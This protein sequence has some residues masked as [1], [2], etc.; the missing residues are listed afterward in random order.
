MMI[1]RESDMPRV[2]RRDGLRLLGGLPLLLAGCGDAPRPNAASSTRPYHHTEA[3]FR[4]PPGSPEPGGGFGDW[5]GFFYRRFVGDDRAITL[6][7]DHVLKKAE[8]L[9]GLDRDSETATWLGHACFLLR[10]D[11]RTV[12][13]DPFLTSHAS[14]FPSFGPERLAPPG[15]PPRELPPIDVVLLSHNHYD[16]LD[17]PTLERLP[18]LGEAALVC[19]LRVGD[20]ID[21]GSFG[22]VHELDWGDRVEARGLTITAVPAV[23][24]SKRTL[25]DRNRSL[26]GGFLVDTPRHRVYFAGDTAYGPVF[27]ELGRTIAAPDLALLPIGAYAPRELMIASHCT[28]EEAVT[29]GRDLGARRLA[30]MHWGTIRLTDEPFLEPPERF[31]RAADEAGYGDRAR[32]MAIGE[33]QRL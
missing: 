14:P 20:Y 33:M 3:G 25:F 9:A 2:R 7:P 30:A 31:R 11:G 24:F 6:P 5:T 28:P 16:H 19:P 1:E 15:L 22:A 12:L 27:E 26:W 17:R 29:I 21:R 10:I 18:G 13:T 23:H 8:V 32:V 4:N